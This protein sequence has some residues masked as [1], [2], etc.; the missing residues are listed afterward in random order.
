MSATS[1]RRGVGPKLSVSPHELGLAMNLP[2]VG[3]SRLFP[4]EEFR[5]ALREESAR[6]RITYGYSAF[7]QFIL[8]P[9]YEHF[10]NFAVCIQEKRREWV[11][12]D[13]VSATWPSE[14]TSHHES[15]LQ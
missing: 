12:F 15:L 10:Y 13:V 3:R 9:L 8:D 7:L 5:L 1:G 14:P 11:D 2:V 4:G 6:V